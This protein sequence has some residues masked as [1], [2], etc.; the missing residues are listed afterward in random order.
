MF[1]KNDIDRDRDDEKKEDAHH[2]IAAVAEN[3]NDDDGD[4]HDDAASWSSTAPP[5]AVASRDN[6]PLVLVDRTATKDDGGESS[7]SSVPQRGRQRPMR[8]RTTARCVPASS[9]SPSERAVRIMNATGGLFA[10]PVH[11]H[12]FHP[13]GGGNDAVG[14]SWTSVVPS[15]RSLFAG[16]FRRCIAC[17]ERLGGRPSIA[18]TDDHPADGSAEMMHPPASSSSGGMLQCAA[19]GAYAHR[20]CAFARRRHGPCP[21][22]V[23]PCEVN[24][25]EIRRA[26]GHRRRP[27]DGGGEVADGPPSCAD[28]PRPRRPGGGEETIGSSRPSHRS[29]SSSSSSSWSIFGRRSAVVD[30]NGGRDGISAV[31]EEKRD[32][33]PTTTIEPRERSPPPAPGV[34]ETSVRLIR[35]TTTTAA[36]AS[37]I[38]RASTVGMVAGGAAGLVIAGPA[39]ALVGCQ[40]G[41]TAVAVGAA[42]EGGVGAAVLAVSLVNAAANLSLAGVGRCSGKDDNDGGERQREL[43]LNANLVLVRPDVDVDPIWAVYANE[44]REQWERRHNTEHRGAKSSSSDGGFGLGH[45]LGR[46]V[47]TARDDDNDE[48]KRKDARYRKDSDILRADASELPMRE[49]VFLLVN[50]ILNDKTSLPGHQYRHLVLKHK[51]RTMFGDEYDGGTTTM[52]GTAGDN[53]EEEE[54]PARS[55]RRDA[56]GVIKHITAT[57]LEVRPGLASSPSVTEL[58][59]SAVEVLV[60]GELYEDCFDEIIRQVE[61]KDESLSSKAKELAGRRRRGGSHDDE[62]SSSLLTSVSPMAIAAL[63]SLPPSRTPTD[64]LACCVTFLER[65]SDHFSSAYDGGSG[66]CIDADALLVLVCRHV[67]AANVPHLHAEVAFVEEFSRDEQLLCGKEGYALITLQA[68]LHYLDGLDELPDELLPC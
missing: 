50:R 2:S 68:S 47:G 32:P 17:R 34:V 12:S 23:P 22:A 52:G 37:S 44:A 36:I 58:S 57:L 28:G 41:R 4:D 31:L 8:Q 38:P 13:V 15:P 14:G 30:A 21:N 67:V 33:S 62:E 40:I 10:D 60:F 49:K 39:G 63:R 6:E 56:H 1:W 43:K 7:S 45:L 16:A 3:E 26:S 35:K 24:L 27:G 54:R 64:K 18:A 66:R 65:V 19:C 25:V 20:S 55:C 61:D 46:S 53:E 9:P 48:E 11:F 59:A 5:T 51:R 42:V 29:P